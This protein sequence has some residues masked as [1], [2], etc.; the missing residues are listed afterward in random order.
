[1]N[2]AQVR[3]WLDERQMY[4]PARPTTIVEMNNGMMKITA[5]TNRC[6]KPQD[7][8][9]EE[10]DFPTGFTLVVGADI[11][12]DAL[13][14]QIAQAELEALIVAYPRQPWGGEVDEQREFVRR[15]TVVA[16]MTNYRSPP[17]DWSPLGSESSPAEVSMSMPH[18]TPP[19]PFIPPQPAPMPEK[20]KEN[21]PAQAGGPEVLKTCGE[22]MRIIT[23][24]SGDAAMAKSIIGSVIQREYDAGSAK[25]LTLDQAHT[26]LAWAQ[27][28]VPDTKAIGA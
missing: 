12:P 9:T 26:L 1:V 27:R 25:D 20:P 17:G 18:P 24:R 15:H 6:A 23:G 2:L 8:G 5:W 28:W 16:L 21:P 14:L 3:Q 4:Y 7:D 13:N 22:V 10:F 19:T 11:G